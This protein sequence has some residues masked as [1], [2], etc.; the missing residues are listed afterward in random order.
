MA[1]LE[2]DRGTSSQELAHPELRLRKRLRLR[3]LRLPRPGSLV[4]LGIAVTAITVWQLGVRNGAID[5]LHFPA[6]STIVSTVGS[7]TERGVLVENLVATLGR[8]GWG[9]LLGGG[10]GLLL[11]LVMGWSA[12][13]KSVVDPFV[14]AIHP[15]PKIAILPLIMVILGVSDSSR[16]VVI[17]SAAFF[18]MLINT[19]AGVTQISP[20]H[21][22][23][24]RVFRA[25]RLKMFRRVALP[26][27][28]PS[29]LAGARLALNTSLLLTIAVEIVSSTDGLGAMIWLGWTTL[30]T[31]EIYAALL[32]TMVFGVA[33]NIFL[34][35]LTRRLVPWQKVG[36]A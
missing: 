20:V 6:P 8:M 5:A 2:S 15:M 9:I 34:G 14:A 16:I 27:A 35:W 17:A 30:K 36:R 13:L 3:R 25:G 31:E 22:D 29:I 32:V 1:H 24:A 10:L 28:A 4:A 33:I 12:F 19:M 11:G 21:F 23:V 7:L 18:P 26:A